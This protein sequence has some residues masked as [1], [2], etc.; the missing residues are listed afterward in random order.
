MTP[1]TKG[2]A[3]LDPAAIER[4]E[5]L[6][7]RDLGAPVP[8]SLAA[9]GTRGRREDGGFEPAGHWRRFVRDAHPPRF[10]SPGGVEIALVGGADPESFG[11]IAAFGLGL[12]ARFETAFA[13][14]PGLPRWRCWVAHA[15]GAPP[16][17]A[18]TFGDGGIALLTIAATEESARPGP[19]RSALLHRVIADSVES[20]AR[21]IC[22]RADA[23]AEGPRKSA[24]AGLLLAGFRAAYRC[25]D[26]VDAGLPAS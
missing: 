24:A 15:E 5:W 23:R 16:A 21:L 10:P 8:D 7:Q 19:S 1:A 2:G 25:P 14:L 13:R 17:A 12:P 6:A 20:G 9:D 4:V 18:A 3:D 22:A 11:A 26:W